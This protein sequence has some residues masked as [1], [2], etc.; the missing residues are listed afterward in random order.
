MNMLNLIGTILISS[1]RNLFNNQHDVLTPTRFTGMTEWNYSRHLANEIVKYIFWLNH[2]TDVTKHDYHNRRP[3]IIFH[4]RGINDLNFLVVE[5]KKISGLGNNDIKKI[6]RD[7]MCEPLL[8]RFG[9]SIVVQSAEDFEVVV[10]HKNGFQDFSQST[11]VIPAPRISDSDRR[12]FI[13]LVS[14]IFSIAGDRSYPRNTQ[15]QAE[16]KDL[17]SEIDR[18]VYELYGLTEEIRLVEESVAN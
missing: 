12:Q 5:I 14:T 11:T 4:K 9:A 6:K 7:W 17:K 3:D 18:L 8:Y 1:I 2:D 13:R 16:V 15:K 10:F